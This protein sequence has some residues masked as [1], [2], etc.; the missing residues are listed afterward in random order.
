LRDDGAKYSSAG[1]DQVHVVVDGNLVTAQN[2]QS[3]ALAL[4]NLIW[5]GRQYQTAKA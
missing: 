3:A 5:I 4:Q 2:P 1:I